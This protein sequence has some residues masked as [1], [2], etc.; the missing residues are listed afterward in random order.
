MSEG[1]AGNHSQ[2]VIKALDVLNSLAGAGRPL[3]AS[4]VAKLCSITRPT[5]YRLLSTLASR[6]YVRS[7]SDYNYTLGAGLLALGSAAL[8]SLD[9][10]S[11]AQSHLEK[12]SQ[13]TTESVYLATM[14]G[15][16]LIVVDHRTGKQP[17]VRRQS[18]QMRPN[19]GN[20]V[21]LHS[22]GMGKALLSGLTKDERL[23]ILNTLNLTPVTDHT[24]TDRETLKQ[25]LDEAA[26]RGYAIDDLEGDPGVRC[27]GAPIYDYQQRPFA[28]MSVAGP[29]HRMTLERI[30]EIAQDLLEVTRALSREMGYS[31]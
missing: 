9:L 7:D 26:Q 2:T 25:N 20:R 31:G 24:I 27:V 10:R 11:L 28:A 14:Y 19:I 13:K 15:N 17:L 1:N 18:L 12:L 5:A 23:A 4:E 29:S 30:S 22:S 3:S 8:D 6:N 16:E 21:S